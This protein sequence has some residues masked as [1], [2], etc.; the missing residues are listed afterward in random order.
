MCMSQLQLS[1]IDQAKPCTPFPYIGAEEDGCR[2]LILQRPHCHPL[3]SEA[4]V[5]VYRR[6]TNRKVLYCTGLKRCSN[7]DS[8]HI[9]GGSCRHRAMFLFKC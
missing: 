9:T 5:A 1:S 6:K 3:L 2:C 8:I 4:A 7:V